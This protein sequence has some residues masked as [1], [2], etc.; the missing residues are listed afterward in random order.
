MK[1]CPV[2]PVLSL[3]AVLLHTYNCET[4]EKV[5]IQQLPHTVSVRE[6]SSL[7]I[8]CSFSTGESPLGVFFKRRFNK[9]IAYLSKEGRV[10]IERDYVERTKIS[11]AMNNFMVTLRHLRGNDT[12][13]YLCEG[14]M[15]SPSTLLLIGTGTLVIVTGKY[16]V[17][18]TVLSPVTV[19]D[20][21]LFDTV[22][23]LSVLL[24]ILTLCIAT[25]LFGKLKKS[26]VSHQQTQCL[27]NTVYEGVR[28]FQNYR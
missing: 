8:T 7:N 19:W 24:L 1:R 18:N 9:N 21:T 13:L 17:Q 12:D 28:M 14:S 4:Q 22:I 2:Y 3:L 10:S 16:P 26:W 20:P 11:G 23:A 6:G 27:Q 25:Y 5:F 15:Q